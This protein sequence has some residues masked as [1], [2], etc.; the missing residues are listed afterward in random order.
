M[1][2]VVDQKVI[3]TT[4][5]R[6]WIRLII[7][8]FFVPLVLPIC[9]GDFWWWQAWVYSLLIIAAGVGGRILGKRRHPGLTAERQRG[10]S[11]QGAKA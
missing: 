6:Q 7:V 11:I 8:Y 5:P 4:S 9:G 1:T 3:Q 10:E 2:K